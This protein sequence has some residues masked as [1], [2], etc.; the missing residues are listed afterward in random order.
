MSARQTDDAVEQLVSQT[1]RVDK[2]AFDDETP[3]G[4]D[5]LDVESLDLVELSETIDLKL[6]IEIPDQ[7]LDEIETVGE[8]KT[9][10]D[11]NT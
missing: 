5:G 6:G 11:D 3:F 1:L 10:V 4:P 8:L 7:A 2:T 9:Y